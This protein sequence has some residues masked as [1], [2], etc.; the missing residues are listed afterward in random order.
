[1]LLGNYAKEIMPQTKMF[2]SKNNHVVLN[3]KDPKK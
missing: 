3:Y 2:Y 1:M